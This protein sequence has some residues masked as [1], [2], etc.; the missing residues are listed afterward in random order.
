MV[1]DAPYGNF[2][3]LDG[4]ERACVMTCALGFDGKW[5]IHPNQ[6]ETINKVFSPSEADVARAMKILAA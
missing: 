5:A 2:K 3:D 6:L 1:I 4:L